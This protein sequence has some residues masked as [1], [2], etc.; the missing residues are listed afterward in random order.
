[1]ISF[2]ELSLNTIRITAQHGDV[3]QNTRLFVCI[4]CLVKFTGFPSPSLTEFPPYQWKLKSFSLVKVS[5]KLDSAR[6]FLPSDVLCCKDS[7]WWHL[8]NSNSR[9]TI[10]N[11]P[12]FYL[13]YVSNS[14]E[15]KWTVSNMIGKGLKERNLRIEREDGSCCQTGSGV[16]VVFLTPPK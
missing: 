1:M 9:S 12:E 3:V 6:N 4:Y 7:C 2:P 15:K 14:I 10:I 13:I 16:V 8:T 11:C 5:Q